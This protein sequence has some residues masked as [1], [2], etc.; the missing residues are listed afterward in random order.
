[1][2][3][4]ILATKLYIPPPR[5]NFVLRPRL[6][7]RLNEGVHRKLTLISAP[8]GFGKT[9]LVSEWIASDDRPTAWL[10]LDEG[11]N[12]PTRFLAYLVAALQTMPSAGNGADIGEEVLGLLNSPQPPPIESILTALLNEIAAIS[13]TFILVLDDYHVLDAKPIDASTS[14]DDALTFLLDHLPPQMHLVITTR[15]DPP[16]PLARYRVQGQLTEVRAADLRFTPSEAADFLT[17]VMGLTLTI[18]E[19]AALEGRTEGWIAGLQMAALSMQGR[20]DISGFIE[21]FAG[22]NRYIV[23]YLVEEV[24]RRQPEHVS[25][26]LLRTAILKRLNGPLCDAVIGQEESGRTLEELERA[27]LFVVPL[28][29]K[30]RWYRYHHLFA[31]VL[32]TRLIEKQADQL[33]TLHQRASDWYE[34]NDQRA[35]A[36]QHALAAGNLERAANLVE[37]TWPALHR[38]DFRSP[39]LLSWLEEL[40]DDLIRARPVLSVGYAWELLNGG[41]F[42]GAEIRLRDAERW[43]EPLSDGKSGDGKD[44]ASGEPIAEM[45]ATKML[46]MDEEEFRSLPAE[47]ASARS[48][49]A[50]AR[51]DVVSTVTYAQRALVLIPKDDHIRRGPA[52]SLLGLAHWATGNLEAAHR[53][54]AEGMANFEAAGNIIFA[55]S[56]VFGLA[57]IRI[58][59]GRLHAAISDY[60]KAL[61]LVMKEGEPALRGTADLH[62]GLSEL[63]REQGD[64]DAAEKQMLRSQELGAQSGQQVYLYAYLYRMCIAQ[65]RIKQSLGDLDGAL[66]LLDEAEDLFTQIH[67]PDFHPVAAMKVRVRLAHGQLTEAQSWVSERSVSVDDDLSYQSEFEHITLARVLIAQYKST[68]GKSAQDKSNRVDESIQQ[69]MG[70]LARLLSAAEARQGFGSVIEILLLQALSH[71]AQGEMAP[72]LVSLER[73]LTLA[74]P[75]GYIR[76]FVDEGPSMAALLQEMSRRDAAKESASANYVARLLAAFGQ[77]Q[78]RTPVMQTVDAPQE[79]ISEPL[80]ERELDVLRLLRSELSG[81]EIAR[82]LVV[83]LNTMR[84]HSKNIY[85]KLGVNNRRTAV[86]RAEE[87][88]LL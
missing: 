13:D 12:E 78:S 10:S 7:E 26:F 16:L 35:D 72:A 53:A 49:L 46:V 42:E 40:P 5:P 38:S 73:A 30:R 64:L 14:V 8:A 21:A 45:A 85:S 61:Q 4:P 36:I 81:P 84:T 68:Q 83:S 19:V 34:A 86:R 33:P 1:M 44:S 52:A 48:Y 54:L 51:G 65:T 74:E 75:E 20:E 41:Q 32:Q 58:A 82:E 62:L 9:T 29:D 28:D 59:Q 3:T 27:N 60:E 31:D 87:L 11:D 17:Q 66:Q 18:E 57:D 47:I 55:I 39:E 50:M 70:L 79:L 24:L 63:Y 69:A 88:G 76:I 23:D 6:I 37:L 67:L 22:D 2:P 43:M 80:S 77:Q 15:E 71:D 25:N 56:G